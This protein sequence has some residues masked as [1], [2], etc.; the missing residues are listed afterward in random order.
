MIDNY[1]NHAAN[2]RTF[3]AWLRSGLAVTAF[4]LFLTRFD[5][6][7][8]G[9]A[10]ARHAVS[11]LSPHSLLDPFRRYDAVALATLG[12]LMILLGG[13]RYARTARAIDSPG[14][15]PAHAPRLEVALMTVVSALVA[16]FCVLLQ[17][18]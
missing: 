15:A 5:L 3:L 6:M 17:V 12:I 8:G 14:T 1:A 16:G 4:G 2:E 10:T 13:A 9:P 11:S 18:R 7:A